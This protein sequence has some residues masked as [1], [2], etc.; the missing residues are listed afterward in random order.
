MKRTLAA[1]L[2]ALLLLSA[3]SGCGKTKTAFTWAE[4]E[5]GSGMQGTASNEDLNVFPDG[6]G[7]TIRHDELREDG[8]PLAEYRY[9]LTPSLYSLKPVFVELAA[10]YTYETVTV[11]V[12]AE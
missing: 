2:S 1:I 12:P 9:V 8:L 7:M 6:T 11:L 10:W 4:K 3:L 5:D